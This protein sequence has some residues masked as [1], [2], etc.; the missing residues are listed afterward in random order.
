MSRKHLA[1]TNDVYGLLFYVIGTAALSY[2]IWTAELVEIFMWLTVK[3]KLGYPLFCLFFLD[4][5]HL[6]NTAK[7][8]ASVG[9]YR[10]CPRHCRC[11]CLVLAP[12]DQSSS[13]IWIRFELYFLVCLLVYFCIMFINKRPFWK[14]RKEKDQKQLRSLRVTILFTNPRVLT[15]GI[16]RI[17]NS[18]GTCMV[19]PSLLWLMHM[20]CKVR[21]STNVWLVANLNTFSWEHWCL[22]LSLVLS[23]TN[24]AGVTVSPAEFPAARIFQ[25]LLVILRHLFSP[26]ASL[27][28]GWGVISFSYL[29]AVCCRLACRLSTVPTGG[30]ERCKAA[31][32]RLIWLQVYFFQ[33]LSALHSLFGCSLV[34]GARCS[35][36]L[37]RPLPCKVRVFWNVFIYLWGK[38]C[39]A[40]KH[41][42]NM[43]LTQKAPVFS[44]GRLVICSAMRIS[45]TMT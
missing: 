10:H 24:S 31:M 35:S 2:L 1:Q 37:L 41:L 3:G 44:P 34:S 26:A 13:V 32:F 43:Y 27:A 40:R 28:V 4:M 8:T 18:I 11:S 30:G 7:Q 19:F 9:F 6:Q 12:R 23:A 29:G 45:D 21:I 14:R 25:F 39:W 20:A 16:I 17:I 36:G 38:A 15:G 22:T 42:L 33:R 5:G